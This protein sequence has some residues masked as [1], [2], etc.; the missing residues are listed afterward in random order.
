[1]LGQARAECVE[2][3]TTVRLVLSLEDAESASG[4]LDLEVSQGSMDSSAELVRDEERAGLAFLAARRIEPSYRFPTDLVPQ[5]H[6]TRTAYMGLP[7]DEAILADLEA[8]PRGAVLVDGRRD[9]QRPTNLPAMVQLVDDGGAVRWTRYA[10]PGEPLPP[11][12]DDLVAVK[13]GHPWRVP[14]LVTS[15]ASVVAAA[16]LYGAAASSHARWEDPQQQVDD[17]DALRRQN[18]T[19]FGGS[20]GVGALAIGAGVGAAWTFR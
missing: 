20:L 3:A 1:M 15:G 12:P 17:E 11:Y 8:I 14:L 16:V 2:A 18:N 7:L 9:T 13:E 4:K 19:L 10:W 6:P 5:E